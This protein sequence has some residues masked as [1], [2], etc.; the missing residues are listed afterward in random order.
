MTLYGDGLGEWLHAMFKIFMYYPFDRAYDAAL[1]GM[2]TEH[3][4]WEDWDDRSDQEICVPGCRDDCAYHRGDDSTCAIPMIISIDNQY[5]SEDGDNDYRCIDWSSCN[6]FRKNTG[7]DSD[8][9]TVEGEFK[10]WEC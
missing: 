2:K 3:D 8:S 4:C 7:A 9:E 6:V 1:T 10:F 5:A